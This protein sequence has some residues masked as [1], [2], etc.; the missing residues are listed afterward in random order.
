MVAD[1][2]VS[3]LN[4]SCPRRVAY[5]PAMPGRRCLT[6]VVASALVCVAA[7]APARAGTF[8]QD[9]FVAQQ[10]ELRR[11]MGR[12]EA[13]GPLSALLRLAEHLPAGTLDQVLR[14]VADSASADPL[15]AAQA[16][17]AL[18]ASEEQ[19]GNAQAAAQRWRALGL[20]GEF[21]VLGPF[22]A[23]GRSGVDR[24]YPPEKQPPQPAL[25]QVPYA[26]KEREVS[27]RLGHGVYR[28]G[29]FLVDA[30]LSP[31]TDAV[32]Y[33]LTYV[34]SDRDRAAVLRVGS[35]GPLKVWIN[36]QEV[37]KKNVLRPAALDEDAVAVRLRAGENVLMMKTVV[38]TGPWRLYTRFTDTEGRS[39]AGISAH[40]DG[41]APIGLG[42][43]A[44]AVTRPRVLP[45]LAPPREL[46]PVLRARAETLS[47]AGRAEAWTDYA[48]YLVL[49]PGQD[50]EAQAAENALAASLD[51]RV[52][53]EALGLMGSVARE[54]DDRRG[55]VQR[56]VLLTADPRERALATVVLGD[57]ARGHRRESVAFA[58]W[59]AAL[60][61]DPD[62]WPASVALAMEE[63][64]AGLSAAAL[65]RLDALPT[66]VKE[67]IAVRRTR[68]G[69]L[70]ALG[71]KQQAHAELRGIGARRRVDVEVLQ[72]LATAARN[73]GDL[74]AAAWCYQ[75]AAFERPDLPFLSI[76]AA[77]M[78]EAEGDVAGARAQLESAARR[79]PD[80]ARLPEELGK[81]LARA[82]QVSSALQ[83]VQR[84]LTLRP[85]NPTLRKYALRLAA[86]QA[87]AP[88][89]GAGADDLVKQYAEDIQGLAAR[90]LPPQP[91]TG[92]AG[93][94]TPGAQEDPAAVLLDRKVVRVHGN[95]LSETFA[96]RVV[97][98]RSDRG[99]R[100]NQEFFVRYSPGTQE[101]E[102]RSAQIY[103]RG[104]SGDVEVSEATGRDDR[105]LSEPWYGMYYDN[106]AQVVV[107]DGL[108]AG[109]ILDV[110]YTVADVSAQNVLADYF[111]DFEFISEAIPKVRW[112]YTLIGPTERQFFF[113]T[114]AV[115]NLT[116]RTVAQGPNTL[117]M[118][119]AVDIP[120]VQAEPSMPGYAEV[121]SYVH[122]STY[123]TWQDVGR[124]WWHLIA[125]QLTPDDNLRRLVKETIAGLATNQDK[126]RALHRA[127]LDG[128]R[129]VGLEF[130]I[131]GF[132]PYKVTQVLT[133]RFGDCKD[134]ASLLYAML[135]E[136]GID[137]ELVLVR[138][139]RGGR[140]APLPASLAVFDHAIVYVPE[141][142]RYLDGTAEFSGM[143]ELPH[144]DQGVM[145]L[146]VTAAGASLDE[147]P[148]FP[149]AANRVERTVTADLSDTGSALV[150]EQLTIAGQAA[151]EWRQHYQTPG[152]RMERYG[153]VW[154]GRFPGATLSALD[155]TGTDDR[156]RPIV[157]T[158]DV[159]V[160]RMAQVGASGAMTLPV[161]TRE[162][163]FVRAY[164]R[165]STRKLDL[166][167]AYPWQHS[168]SLSF[169]IPDG[170][171]I[172]HA[173]PLRHI[174]TPFGV[175][176]LHF[177]PGADGRSLEVRSAIGINQYR[178]VAA[179]YTAF[180]AFLGAV[181]AALGEH[182]VL[183]RTGAGAP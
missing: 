170:W 64:S 120:K 23:Q 58:H 68:R 16:A 155:I 99:G 109:D 136:A 87:G 40:T 168:E 54:E 48:R 174:E 79:N 50:V 83:Q 141:L 179:D 175:F 135:R 37:L 61:L 11:R 176:D 143:D 44:A 67:V 53:T 56:L 147:T 69:I 12:P 153:K 63:Q 171:R 166:V 142:G 145:V 60:A 140:I 107:F 26:G 161:T 41:A 74:R 178:I 7:T 51:A 180:R 9:R 111:G 90:V 156:N 5:N 82:G 123:R 119:S 24:V 32:A 14:D 27:W 127:V 38:T 10:M 146:R 112:D 78:L 15:V 18:A 52:T 35:A 4:A 92:D 33:V 73:S 124:W 104:A 6:T 20:V 116:A 117:H 100:E 151:P 97:H 34:R 65:A 110:Q 108:K 159:H 39:A 122:V 144:Q 21:W 84:A 129:Y 157:V 121:A 43:A 148:V 169:K 59:R 25:D 132:K 177:A 28:Q 158:A 49:V 81:L 88:P 13:V 57:M 29:A 45:P 55:A 86:E 118:F 131:H 164:G 163:E 76:E 137:S 98:V 125:D 3:W 8:Y 162:V 134:K 80:E 36:G 42:K 75:T 115:A 167:L 70:E 114:P 165:L 181:D 31:A 154:S 160:P 47:K 150:R 182:I 30:L 103:R 62:C 133:R 66:E 172:G 89:R 91:R 96:Q 72:E 105:D 77:R 19:S 17:S 1:T 106:R 130:G 22:D 71:R 85:Q 128:T 101:V 138:T 126:I 152:E 113:N 95:G 139:R 94:T 102:I 149:A 183:Q 2:R 46:G 93:H 173:P